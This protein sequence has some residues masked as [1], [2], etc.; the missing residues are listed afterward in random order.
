MLRKFWKIG[1]VCLLSLPALSRGADWPQWM[2]PQ[3]DGVWPEKSVL[4]Q[5]P[6]NGPKLRWRAEVA[7]G[8][9]GP[10]VAQGRVI[11]IDW[12]AKPGV[13]K[14]KD[15]FDRNTKAGTERILCFNEV[16]GKPLWKHEYDCPYTISYAAGP[17]CTPTIDGDRVYTLGA[18]GHLTCLNAADG[19]VIWQKQL[20]SGKD[21]SPVPLWGFAGH[22][23]VLDDLLIV[24]SADVTGVLTALDKATGEK[25][26]SALPAKE[27]GY[28]PPMLY[29]PKGGTEQLIYWHAT[30][31]NSLNPR[32]GEVYWTQPWGPVKFSV[33]ISTPRIWRSPTLGDVLMISSSNEG[34]M[35]L[36]LDA[37]DPKSVKTIWKRTGKRGRSLE[38][39]NSLMASPILYQD[40]IYGVTGSGE[41]RC[42]KAADGD[43]VWE[44]LQATHGGEEPLMWS[45]GFMVPVANTDRCFI[46][47]EEG[48]LVLMQLSPQGYKELGHAHLIDATNLDAG[49]PVLWSHPAFANHSI[50]WKNDKEMLCFSLEEPAQ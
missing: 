42:I 13:E 26:W 21:E 33:A 24:P 17:R 9:A 46:A 47:N 12:I 36:G 25:K 20:A 49:R 34:S 48:D 8:Y 40:H 19:K 50:Y 11:V 10:A 31:V 2:G 38:G 5:I 37:A 4:K 23:L 18:Q 29:Q 44:T 3:R 22:P 1:V 43:I 15:P 27:P 16:D 6:A 7:G 14:T 35:L 30:G 39:I 41:L 32:T 45:T 28:S